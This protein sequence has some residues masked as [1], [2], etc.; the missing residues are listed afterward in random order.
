MAGKPGRAAVVE[1][2]TQ[3][4]R[5]AEDDVLHQTGCG[6]LRRRKNNTDQLG[7]LGERSRRAIHTPEAARSEGIRLKFIRCDDGSQ[8]LIEN[9]TRLFINDDPVSKM[10]EIK[11]ST[12]GPALPFT[13][14]KIGGRQ[15]A[16]LYL[17]DLVQKIE[18]E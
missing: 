1:R 3:A 11:A 9:I 16:E 12:V 10:S 13:V 4:D 18:C 17:L 6:R 7:I 14:T 2:S 5:A 15:A 8:L